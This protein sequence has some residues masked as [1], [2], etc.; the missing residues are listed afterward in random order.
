MS[1]AIGN[2]NRLVPGLIEKI[3]PAKTADIQK[4][5]QGEPGFTEIFSNM[6]QSVDSIQKDSTQL[7]EAFMNGEPVELHEMMIKIQESGI[8]TDLLLEIR[9]KIITAYNEIM[10]MQI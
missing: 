2:V 4:A 1:G 3:N 7:Q 6:L 8:A 10:R 5:G 9:N